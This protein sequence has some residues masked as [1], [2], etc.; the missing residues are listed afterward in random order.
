MDVLLSQIQEFAIELGEFGGLF[1]NVSEENKKEILLQIVLSEALK[2]SEIEGEYFSRED[3]MSSLQ[4]QLGLTF[5]FLRPN[6]YRNILLNY[7]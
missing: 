7:V 5:G 2:T 3:V 6:F 4:K 1:V